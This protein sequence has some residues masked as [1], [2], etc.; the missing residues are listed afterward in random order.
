MIKL[1]AGALIIGKKIITLRGILAY[2]TALALLIANARFSKEHR[3]NDT[4]CYTV[5]GSTLANQIA[6]RVYE[7]TNP[8]IW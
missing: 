1:A 4:F 2:P 6:D 7:P 5:L 3:W 8:T